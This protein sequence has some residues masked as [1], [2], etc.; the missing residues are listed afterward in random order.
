MPRRTPSPWELW[1][2]PGKTVNK[3]VQH[4]PSEGLVFLDV[5]KVVFQVA[6]TSESRDHGGGWSN[7]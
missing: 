2:E 5:I 1:F 7:A 3:S 6:E 4:S